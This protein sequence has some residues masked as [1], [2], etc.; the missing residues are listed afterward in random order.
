MN[1]SVILLWGV[2]I[3]GGFLLGSIMFSRMLPLIICKKDICAIS[4]DKN[5]GAAN[6]F[7][8]LGIPMGMLCLL[9]DL[10]KGFIPVYAG[11][12]LLDVRHM[13]FAA[14]LA[15]PVLGHAIAPFDHFRG[16]K[17]IATAFGVMLGIMPITRIGFLLA[18]LYIFFSVIFRINP[19]RLRSIVTFSLF[20]VISF[21][22]M[23]LTEKGSVAFGCALVSAIATAK[24]TKR[25]SHIPEEEKS[26]AEERA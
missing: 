26:K 22:V 19:T 1:I 11:V 7:S 21:A 8:C 17:C 6:V 18:A 12:C 3:V 13:A 9:C 5:P 20:G 4:P 14:V 10:L 2:I 24:H 25:F 23:I 16:G 15:A